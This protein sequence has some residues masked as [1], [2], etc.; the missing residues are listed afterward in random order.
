MDG[1]DDNRTDD[2]NGRGYSQGDQE[3]KRCAATRKKRY[4]TPTNISAEDYLQKE[5]IKATRH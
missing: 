1:W 5:K 2:H 4:I 3:K